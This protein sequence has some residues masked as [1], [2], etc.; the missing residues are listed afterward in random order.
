M[1]DPAVSSKQMTRCAIMGIVNITGDSFSEGPASAPES[2]VRR[3]LALFEDGADIL[4]LGAESTRPGS[5]AVSPAEECERLL[6][7]LK[8]L[9]A[10]LPQVPISVDTRN[11]NTAAL[12]L[13]NG[14]NIINDVSMGNDPE[15]LQAVAAANAE[16]I[17]CHSR[18]TPDQMQSEEFTSYPGGVRQDVEKELLEAC[19]KAV[20][21]GVAKEKITLDPGVGFAKTAAQCRELIAESR[22]MTRAYPW[23][24]GISR[25][26]FMGGTV[27]SRGEET[28]RLELELVNS[29]ASIIRT[30]DVRSLR[31]ALTAKGIL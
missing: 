17:L 23:L 25:K 18:S 8:E 31:Q 30:H 15:L 27:D 6:P 26:S 28:L 10:R 7:V 5:K 3:A 2:A 21:A 1:F 9:R 4:D 22:L 13:Q 16:L 20:K 19:E 24:W 14:A 29:G 11:G 12:A